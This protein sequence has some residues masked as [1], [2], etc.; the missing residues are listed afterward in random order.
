[1]SYLPP[2]M[3]AVN[4]MYHDRLIMSTGKY[5]RLTI[6]ADTVKIQFKRNTIIRVKS[7]AVRVKHV[8]SLL[9][10]VYY[11]VKLKV[12]WA[13]CPRSH[14]NAEKLPAHLTSISFI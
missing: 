10:I 4:I 12:E 13:Y 3:A 2:G 11:Y 14:V 9:Y 7:P 8:Y 1:M 6:N 5:A